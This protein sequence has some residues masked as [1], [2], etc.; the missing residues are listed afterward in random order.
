MLFY[1]LITSII[2]FLIYNQIPKKRNRSKNAYKK[3][4]VLITGASSGIGKELAYQYASMGAKISLAARRKT[5]LEEIA[6]ICLEK[7]AE[8]VL[9]FET[10]VSKEEDCKH[11]IEDTI[12]KYGGID[13]LILNAGISSLVRFDELENLDEQ[14]KLMDVNYWGAIHCTFYALDSLKQSSGSIC[15]ISSLVGMTGVPTRTGYSAS[16]HALHGFF[17]S[18]KIELENQVKISIVCPG[19]VLTEIHHK[20]IGSTKDVKREESKFMTSQECSKIIIETIEDGKFLE[21]MTFVGKLGYLLKP[22]AQPLLDKFAAAKI[23]QVKK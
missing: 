2:L 22:F 18:L 4:R 19:F 8:E 7:G 17:H 11:F 6:K 10:D 12:K 5:T 23:Q 16:K 3:K 9:I 20:A 13:I 21:I 14:K 1:L 15:V